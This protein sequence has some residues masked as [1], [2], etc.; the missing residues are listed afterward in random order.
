MAKKV[1]K[2]ISPAPTAPDAPAP[3]LYLDLEGQDVSQLKDLNIGDEVEI[4]VTG[5]VKGLSQRQRVSYEDEKKTV[6]TGT[7]DLE[8]YKVQVLEE[9]SNVFTKMAGEDD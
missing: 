2:E 1:K 9:E 5:K 4:L 8:N 7:I 6:K 3:R